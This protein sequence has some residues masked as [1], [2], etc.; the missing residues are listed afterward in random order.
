MTFPL[1]MVPPRG[2]EPVT[3]WCWRMKSLCIHRAGYGPSEHQN[4]KF[5]QFFPPLSSIHGLY[6]T[7]AWPW[8]AGEWCIMGNLLYRVWKWMSSIERPQPFAPHY[9]GDRV[10][11]VVSVP[12][13]SLQSGT[14]FVSAPKNINDPSSCLSAL[15][16]APEVSSR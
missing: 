13:A 8:G 15:S 4:D 16:V 11:F 2:V 7:L 1:D 9:S 12:L 3:Q 6:L 5:Y 14:K 10:W